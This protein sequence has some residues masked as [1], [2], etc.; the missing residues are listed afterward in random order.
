MTIAPVTASIARLRREF[1]PSLIIVGHHY[2][3]D[4]VIQHT[5]LRG[6][7]LELARK[8]AQATS[9]HI[10]F[11]GV[12]F[13]AE[14]AALLAR[15][16]QK[17]YL[18]ELSA[19]CSMA[20]MSPAPI[21]EEVL[22]RLNSTGRKVIPLAYVNSE[23]AVKTVVGAYGGAVCTSAN[24]VTMLRWAREQG[25]AVLFL[26]DKN[27][28]ANTADILGISEDKRHRLDIRGRGTR[29]DLA[30]ADKADLLIWPGECCVH[31]RFT[32]DM[33]GGQR[34]AHPG[35]LV[36]V[37]PESPPAVVRA[38]DAAGSTSF[39][40]RYVESAPAG[41]TVVIGTEINLVR[42]LAKEHAGRVNVVPLRVSECVNMAKVTEERLEETLLEIRA[43]N[44]STLVEAPEHLRANA[45]L[46]LERMLA[47]CA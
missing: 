22:K 18:P 36:V 28:A 34:A 37:H 20:L 46:S 9:E 33:I 26:P 15:P 31:T 8:V 13:M 3:N 1:G 23:L 10:V 47:A 44:P 16:G 5:D 45:K 24:A 25:D 43:G 27:L 7:S 41:S 6:D 11:C 4:A 2:Q 29:V 40:I 12:F 21:V 38:S 39:I 19:D 17:V 30:A 14:S 35:A 32:V 42:R